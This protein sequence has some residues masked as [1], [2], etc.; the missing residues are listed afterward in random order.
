MGKKE[1]ARIV[2]V[3]LSPE[4]LGTAENFDDIASGKSSSEAKARA[5][6]AAGFGGVE[7]NFDQQ[8]TD[9]VVYNSNQIKSADPVTR[10]DTGRVIP[11]S[12]RFT[13][14]SNDIR[15]ALAPSDPRDP[16][17]SLRE[18]FEPL[19]H[20][21]SKPYDPGTW[22]QRMFVDRFGDRRISSIPE[23]RIQQLVAVSKTAQ[24]EHKALEKAIKKEGAPVDVLS[25]AMG[26]TAPNITA[27]QHAEIDATLA[28]MLDEASALEDM[29]AQPSTRRSA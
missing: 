11:L 19:L 16:D 1:Q 18:A 15:Y 22:W 5:L 7:I 14:S 13:P 2:S 26:S 3:Y 8:R 17:T 21:W 20:D 28:E 24:R 29:D 10:D 6:I 23:R 25:A 12:E 27:A 4:G 9:Y